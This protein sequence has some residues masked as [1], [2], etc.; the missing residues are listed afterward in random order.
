MTQQKRSHEP[1]WIELVITGITAI[2]NFAES[3]V[4]RLLAGC[5]LLFVAPIACL[6]SVG[7]YYFTDWTWDPV[8]YSLPVVAVIIAAAAIW[9]WKAAGKVDDIE[10]FERLYNVNDE[11]RPIQTVTIPPAPILGEIVDK[12]SD[13]GVIDA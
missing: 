8:T 6:S 10:K 11:S 12:D 7:F 4:I 2:P 3:G 13:E 1:T 9:M 5:L